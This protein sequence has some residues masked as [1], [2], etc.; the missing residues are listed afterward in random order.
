MVWTRQCDC[1]LYWLS[2]VVHPSWAHTRRD[3]AFFGARPTFAASEPVTRNASVV[4][5][6]MRRLYPSREE[7]KPGSSPPLV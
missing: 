7:D 5:V 3:E 1:R 2:T 6:P 4:L